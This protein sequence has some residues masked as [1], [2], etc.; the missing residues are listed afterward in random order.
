MHQHRGGWD[1]ALHMLW[2]L[3]SMVWMGMLIFG[4]PTADLERFFMLLVIFALGQVW[5]R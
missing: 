1:T 2:L 5:E 4:I 3:T